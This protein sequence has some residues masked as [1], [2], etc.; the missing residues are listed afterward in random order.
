MKIAVCKHGNE[1]GVII[2]SGVDY[3]NEQFLVKARP[4]PCDECAREMLAQLVWIVLA[5]RH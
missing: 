3:E 5:D 2:E 1:A 4:K